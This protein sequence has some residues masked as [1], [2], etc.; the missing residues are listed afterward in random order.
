MKTPKT[1]L[2]L[3]AFFLQLMLTAQ[4][5]WY[6]NQDGNN[7][8][9]NGTFGTSIE[10]FTSTTFIACYQWSANGDDITWKIS[11]SNLA[12]VEQKCLFITGTSAFVEAKVGHLNSIYIL[13]RSF[14]P[15][16]NAVYTVYKLDSDLNVKSQKNIN[17]PNSFN[18]FN[19]NAFELDYYDNI[20]LAGD[21]QYPDGL[22]FGP[23]SFVLKA[24]RNL[25]TRWTK[26]DS[27]QTSFTQLHIDRNGFV[28]VIEDFYTFYPD[29]HVIKIS[30]AGLVAGTKTYS[31]PG[32]Y[33]LHSV[34]DEKDN[35]YFY[36]EK[37]VGDT[38]MG[39]YLQKIS[40]NKGTVAFSKTLFHSSAIQL[41]D[42]KLDQ[43]GNMF[44]LIA[45][46]SNQGTLNK[47]SRISTANGSVL[48]NK[49]FYYSEDSCNLK[50]IALNKNDRF[51]VMGERSGNNWFV[52]GLIV[53]M[54]KNGSI[55]ANYASPDSVGFQKNHGLENG[56]IDR[57]GQLIA[58]GNTSDFDTTIYSGTYFR[59]FTAKF[60]KRRNGDC[61][62]DFAVS[63]RGT[64]TP[65]VAD[66][67]DD[68]SI[69]PQATIYPNPAQNQV[70]I[71]NLDEQ[72]YNQ[73]KV[74]DM[75]GTVV[76]QLSV[77][78]TTARID[79]SNLVNGMYILTIRSSLTLKEKSIRFLVSR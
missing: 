1:L 53:G 31:I 33:S 18:I 55:E 71:I 8:Y 61:D 7:N 64:V 48:W 2:L 58:I 59:S 47:V 36:G 35:L 6:Q 75:L 16:Q 44:T 78:G 34:L 39:I 13:M 70:T 68:N 77:N 49:S 22:G 62:D 37:S 3:P 72:D 26:V 23:A 29:V 42:L 14:P 69:K 38:A 27:T 4:V 12:G 20:Y 21:G 60:T 52:K 46:N 28:K 10:A 63:A 65:V 19:L 32:R 24:D 25:N 40:A 50:K 15:G 45:Q 73:L 54:K 30:P 17:F 79:L 5:Q 11:K 43:D 56:F 76:K 51:F 57:N 41:N 67:P 74:C 9:P 66:L